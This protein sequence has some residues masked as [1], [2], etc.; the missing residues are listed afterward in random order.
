MI[1]EEVAMSE[2]EAPTEHLHEM[3]HEEVQKGKSSGHHGGK[4]ERWTIQ[5]ALSTALLA[6]LAALAAL[7]AGHHANEAIL[8]QMKATDQWAFYQAKSIK[9]AVITTKMEMLGALGK[10]AAAADEE[11]VQ[12]YVKE[13]VQIEE[14]GR[15][16]ERS[17][18]NHLQR[19]ETLA[20]T[21]ALLQVAIALAAISVLTKT[22]LLWLSG[23]ALGAV[24]LLFFLRGVL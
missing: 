20:R 10:E 13:Q 11:K 1:R 14:T 16:R 12:Q 3:I 4:A 21:V 18:E 15:E 17:S 24:G 8:D 22:R 6:V 19:H 2:I 5:V 9:Q 23:L 7:L